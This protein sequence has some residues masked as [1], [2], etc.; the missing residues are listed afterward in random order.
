MNR[1]PADQQ[2]RLE[3]LDPGRSFI[4]QAPAGSGKTG[5]L[6][7]RF[8][9]LL[10]GVENPEEILAIT[11][12]RKAAAEMRDR[13]LEALRQAASGEAPEEAYERQTFELAR[14]ALAR[15]RERGWRLLENPTRLRVRTID[16]FCQYLAGQAPLLSGLGGSA[17]VAEEA[18]PLYEEAARNTLE[19]LE[20]EEAGEALALLLEQRDNDTG[21]LATLLAEMLAR[22]D[23]WLRHIRQGDIREVLESA[24]AVAVEQGLAEA[25]RALAPWEAR[26]APLVRFAADNLAADKPLAA[27]RD[28]EELPPPTADRLP[29]WRAIADLLLTKEGAWRQGVNKNQ[30]FPAGCDEKKSMKALLEELHAHPEAAT[31]LHNLRSLP[32]PAYR[33]PEWQVLEAL[34]R[35]LHRAVAHLQLVF[36]ETGR[37]DFS[38]VMLRALHALGP[39]DD[40]TDLALRLDYRIQHLLVD[41][42]QDTS[43][44]QYDLLERL[45]AGWQPGDGRTL[46]LVGD[47]MQSIYRFREAEVGL[48]LQVWRHGLGDLSLVPLRLA[49]NFRSRAGIVEWVNDHFPRILPGRDDPFTGAVRFAPSVA[50]HEGLAGEA[51]TV[52]ARLGRD[53]RA[54]ARQ[55]VEIVRDHPAETDG[56]LA[57]LV[58]LSL[59]HL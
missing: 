13:I 7:Q 8:L 57:I 45:T 31:A 56:E 41:E 2:A 52:H 9:V 43:R 4:V 51:V 39:P 49:V 32:D 16:A 33:E 17:G 19:E 42:F 54:E 59:I 21:R 10:A 26:L 40:P 15:D 3:A 27:C 34:S 28:L 44:N 22:R 18:R 47:P 37:V 24:L 55:V 46:F 1:R 11:F 29:C 30:G 50:F 53:D 23:Q 12:T 5:L 14:K 20:S 48:F 36:G 25:A 6:T 58:R 38:E 35:V